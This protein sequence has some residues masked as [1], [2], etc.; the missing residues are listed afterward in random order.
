MMELQDKRIE[1]ISCELRGC[2]SEETR[3]HIQEGSLEV[4]VKEW[5]PGAAAMDFE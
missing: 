2:G 4:D 3:S 1:E 5:I